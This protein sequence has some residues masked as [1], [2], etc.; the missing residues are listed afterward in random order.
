[1][2]RAAALA[3]GLIS[4]GPWAWAQ[5]QSPSPSPTPKAAKAPAKPAAKPPA[6]GKVYTDADL[7]PPREQ[8]E[9]RDEPEA[10]GAGA[11]EVDTTDLVRPEDE[12]AWRDRARPLHEG[13]RALQERV[14]EIEVRL[15]NLQLDLDPQVE[16]LNPF[17]LQ[18]LEAKKRETAQELERTRQELA[19]AQKALDD[20]REEARRRGVPPG[21]LDQPER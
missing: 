14:Q 11:G 17:R 15:K 6:K 10:R 7:P 18:A 16:A 19:E 20:L 5:A 4:L 12:A 13:V 3:L 8:P 9:A 2:L 1:M 21:W